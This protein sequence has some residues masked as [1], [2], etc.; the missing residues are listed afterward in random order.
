MERLWAGN[1][2]QG[3]KILPAKSEHKFWL[4]DSHSRRRTDSCLL[5]SD[6]HTCVV[7]QACLLIYK[8][9]KCSLKKHRNDVDLFSRSK[10]TIT[11]KL[12]T[13]G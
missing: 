1:M 11:S 2:A 5:S 10:K 4:Q 6:L 9:F 3:R 7:A 8:I 12:G 13:L